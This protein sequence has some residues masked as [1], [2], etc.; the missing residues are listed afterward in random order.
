MCP[1]QT[2][3]ISDHIGYQKGP[4]GDRRAARKLRSTL[5]RARRPDGYEKYEI[6]FSRILNGVQAIFLSLSLSPSSPS[7]SVAPH[8]YRGRISRPFCEL[9]SRT[10]SIERKAKQVLEREL[11]CPPRAFHMRFFQGKTPFLDFSIKINHAGIQVMHP[12]ASSCAA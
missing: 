7:R 1:E 3:E 12:R 6:W 5:F 8:A 2:G 9:G 11:T 10:L 4:G